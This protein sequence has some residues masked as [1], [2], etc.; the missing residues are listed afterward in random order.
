[1]ARTLLR[2]RLARAAERWKVVIRA[3][4]TAAVIAFVVGATSVSADM[5]LAG[6]LLFAGWVV[7]AVA[8]AMAPGLATHKKVSLAVAVA[9]LFVGMEG[10]LVWR[11]APQAQPKEA[12]STSQSNLLLRSYY[13]GCAGLDSI[14]G[15]ATFTFLSNR[16]QDS[17]VIYVQE[18]QAHY[19][20]QKY[21]LFYIPKSAQD[22]QIITK[23]PAK[24]EDIISDVEKQ[25]PRKTWALNDERGTDSYRLI[26]SRRV[27]T[28]HERR[29]SAEELKLFERA[30]RARGLEVRFKGPD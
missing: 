29:F 13:E 4:E 19:L 17:Y 24:Y 27:D 16:E 10:F 11:Q 15:T 8:I 6:F 9:A 20:E 5:L 22:A 21:Y 18:C 7:A 23:L 2:E 28:F 25:Y 14:S 26:F 12:N 30:F 1:M 3:G